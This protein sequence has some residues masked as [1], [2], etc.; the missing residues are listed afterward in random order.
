MF[1]FLIGSTVLSSLL[2]FVIVLIPAVIVHELGHFLAARATGITVL[3]FG[4]GFPPRVAKLFTWRETEFTLNLI[5]LGGFVRP[6]GEDMIQAVDEQDENAAESRDGL[7]SERAILKERGVDHPVSIYDVKP[8]PRIFFMAAGALANFIMAVVVFVFVGMIG[9][10]Q[11]VGQRF[12]LLELEPDSVFETAGFQSND[13]IHSVDGIVPQSRDDL[14]NIVRER[15]GQ[16]VVVGLRR[17]QADDNYRSATIDVT[18][19]RELV[20]TWTALRAAVRVVMVMADTPGEQAGLQPDD[21][22]MAADGVSFDAAFDPVLALQELTAERAGQPIVLSVMRAGEMLD[23]TITP[24]ENPPVGEGRIGIQISGEITNPTNGVALVQAPQVDFVPQSFNESVAYGVAE[25]TTVFRMIGE[26]PSRIIQGA[27]EPGETRIISVV[28][29]SQLGGEI[30]QDS[31]EENNFVVFLRFVALISIA[32]GI[33]NLLPIPALDGGRIVFAFIELVRGKP[34]SPER[35]GYVHMLG[36]VFLLSL[37]V[38]LI[39]NDVM[40]P[41]TDLL[42]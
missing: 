28:G 33:T 38:L 11:E 19:S 15:E 9:M 1:D 27:T 2:A 13:W 25:T 17:Q 29:V 30:L 32:L 34:V 7:Y 36:L 3:E 4:I 6:F 41:V 5:P 40:N 16:T 21:R 20:T 37:G 35:E 8:L 14:I 39:I 31:L 12:G 10:P 26:L 22:I 24:R 42:P 18:L 23:L